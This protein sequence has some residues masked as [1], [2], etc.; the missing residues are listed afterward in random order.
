[1]RAFDVVVAHSLPHLLD[2]LAEYP[3]AR[4]VAGAT[5][6][7]PLVRAGRWR[8]DPAVDITGI[9]DLR[10]L[11]V[12]QSFVEIGALVT[13]GELATSRLVRK[14]ALAL[15]QAAGSVA[16]PQI[17]SRATL[18]GNICTASPA[19]DAIPALLALDAEVNLLS[20]GGTR[21]LPLERLL[22]GP[23]LTALATDEVVL[24]VRFRIL[25]PQAGSSFVKLGRRSAMAI[26]VANAAA[27]IEL[28]PDGRISTARLALGSVAPTVVRCR[29]VESALA[30]QEGTA[31]IPMGAAFATAAHLVA[32]AIRPIDDV[33]ASAAYRRAVAPEIAR[34]AL[35]S[36]WVAAGGPA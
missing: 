29:A 28:E 2:I 31:P 25:G 3:S 24:G 23:G 20:P 27:V 18:G 34:R 15:A 4:L 36:A 33:R 30:V 32:E 17:R 21:V 9:S 8:P 11:R 19:A 14:N 10:Y 22:L 16:D 6:F 35:E 1:M 5:D 26:S 13:H 7:I 12:N